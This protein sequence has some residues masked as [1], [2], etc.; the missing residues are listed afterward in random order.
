[1]LLILSS[2]IQSEAPEL[3]TTS[4]INR[5]K[6]AHMYLRCIAAA[7]LLATFLSQGTLAGT[8][9]SDTDG[10]TISI[11]QVERVLDSAPPEYLKTLIESD[12]AVR[13]LLASL[14]KREKLLHA[15]EAKKLH[16]DPDVR[17]LIE[18]STQDILIKA[19]KRNYIATLPA[20]DFTKVAHEYYITHTQEFTT[21]EQRKA[22]HILVTFNTPEEKKA[23]QATIKELRNRVESGEDFAALAKEFSAD[24]SAQKGGDLGW[25]KPGK[26]VKPFETALFGLSKENPVSPVIETR[27]GFHIIKLEDVKPE[28]I[29]AFDKV[30][31]ALVAKE[32]QDYS[33]QQLKSYIEEVTSLQS[34]VINGELLDQIRAKYSAQ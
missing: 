33:K 15:A 21:P 13:S 27:F 7:A 24:S 14:L 6:E 4:N 18:K 12:D 30:K 1:M 34:P 10:R 8:I 28:H 17:A 19:L 23:S 11:D 9:I 20:K 5:L 3:D 22:R 29:K 26:T 31:E 16:E 25:I 32:K 2:R